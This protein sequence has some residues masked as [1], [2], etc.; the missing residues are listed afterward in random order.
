MHTHVNT[1][2]HSEVVQGSYFPLRKLCLIDR[3]LWE[4][5]KPERENWTHYRNGWHEWLLVWVLCR[6]VYTVKTL[7]FSVCFQ[8]RGFPLFAHVCMCVS[9]FWVHSCE[10]FICST[11]HLFL[12]YPTVFSGRL[13]ENLLVAICH[14]LSMQIEG[15]QHLSHFAFKELCLH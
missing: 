2:T 11:P 4:P 8:S 9:V 14:L 12:L 10:M 5:W 1:Y 15:E 3:L 7:H 6:S 13:C